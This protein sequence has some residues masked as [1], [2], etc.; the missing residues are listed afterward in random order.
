MSVRLSQ[1]GVSVKQL[2]PT[3]KAA[4]SVSAHLV[5]SVMEVVTAIDAQVGNQALRVSFF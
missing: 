2:A 5:S 4:S 3:L 1:G